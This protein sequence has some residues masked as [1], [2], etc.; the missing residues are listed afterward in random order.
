MV[1]GRLRPQAQG[2]GSELNGG[3]AAQRSAVGRWRQAW[4]QRDE[5]AVSCGC[6][7]SRRVM[8][9][10]REAR[11]GR[12]GPGSGPSGHGSGRQKE[13]ERGR[14]ARR[15][16]AS[17]CVDTAGGERALQ[18]RGLPS[19]GD[20]ATLKQSMAAAHDVSGLGSLALPLA[21]GAG[22]PYS[23]RPPCTASY[24]YTPNGRSPVAGWRPSAPP[25]RRARTRRDGAPAAV[26]RAR[27][28]LSGRAARTRAVSDAYRPAT[29]AR[30][31]VPGMHCSSTCTLRRT[32]SRTGAR[33][34]C[35][36]T[37]CP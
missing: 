12:A 15:G 24:P 19:A 17:D 5:E 7:R 37:A 8:A 4:E 11:E 35:S 2:A 10:G 25:R 27:G 21:G 20:A 22:A 28:L 14:K 34:A 23:A 26:A 30:P 16:A 13:G 32:A 31:R 6:W 1:A 3:S 36:H 18:S 33:R 29:G 9:A